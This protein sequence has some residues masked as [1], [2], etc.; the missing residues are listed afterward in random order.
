MKK[1]VTI[2]GIIGLVII[3]VFYVKKEF[4]KPV[5]QSKIT[6]KQIASLADSSM[7]KDGD[8]IFQTSLSQQSHAIQ[9]ATHSKYSHCGLIF[10]RKSGV[11]EWCVLEAVQPVKWTPLAE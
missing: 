11:D 5:T 1:S 10:K 2:F 6:S 9:L 7:I 8:I 3:I 4:Y